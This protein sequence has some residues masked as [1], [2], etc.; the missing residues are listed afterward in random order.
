[1]LPSERGPDYQIG[2]GSV[3]ARAAIE[4][5]GR[6]ELASGSGPISH[7]YIVQDEFRVY[8]FD[9]AGGTSKLRATLVWNDDP[10]NLSV[11]GAIMNNLRLVLRGPDDELH[12]PWNLDPDNPG[13]PA[14]RGINN[15]DNVKQVSVD[16][17]EQGQWA[18]I[19]FGETLTGDS[20][21]YSVACTHNFSLV[22]PREKY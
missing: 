1:M 17:P 10:G 8:E 6:A 2:W 11:D 18:L 15:R 4:L 12:S 3:N 7:D 16:T 21:S 19:V 22:P 5:I 9:V 14:T 13:E 20:L